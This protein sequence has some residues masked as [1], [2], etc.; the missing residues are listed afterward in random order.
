MQ[1][2][3]RFGGIQV[4]LERVQYRVVVWQLVIR[5]R[6][7]GFTAAQQGVV[8]RIQ[9]LLGI[10]QHVGGEIQWR[11][12][13][14]GEQGETQN[15]AVVLGEQI[16]HQTEV[17]QR[18]GHLLAVDID[19]AVVQPV[20]HVVGA[21]GAA[22]LGDLVFVVGEDQVLSAAMDVDHVTQMLMDHGGTFDVPARAATAPGGVP[23]RLLVAGRLPE[24][25][26][27]GVALVVGHFHPGT[28][29]H[30]FQ[31]AAGKL[32]VVGHGFH[33]KQHLAIRLV[34]VALFHQG[35]DHL[36]HLGDVIGGLG[37]NIRG[38]RVQRCHVFGKR[39]GEAFGEGADV[40]AVFRG[41]LD[42]L[43]INV[44]DVAGV[45]HFRVEP[46]QQAIQH[47]KHHHRA[48]VANV[49]EVVNRG[50]THVEGDAVWVQRNEVVLFPG[51]GVL[52][53]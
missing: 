27:A 49:D 42:D 52:Q 40:L 34:G 43:V 24:D 47:I 23:A 30:V 29:E 26:V 5:F 7:H 12:V 22:A 53:S 17:A 8:E 3:D 2:T 44:G 15:F 1:G 16:A 18:L 31:F 35:G 13:V 36:D 6:R 19:V 46:L 38:F 14:A 51:E 39:R 25:E 20:A 41:S 11:A 4:V 9:P 28:G 33:R 48:G 45:D 32:A 37:D 50:A 10:L 21:V